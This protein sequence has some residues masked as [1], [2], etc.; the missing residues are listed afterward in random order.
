MLNIYIQSACK[1]HLLERERER[2][3]GSH[4]KLC[5]LK[6]YR[7]FY[8][9]SPSQESRICWIY[10]SCPFQGLAGFKDNVR[11]FFQT[12]LGKRPV[13]EPMFQ[14]KPKRCV[15]V[16]TPQFLSQMNAPESSLRGGAGPGVKT[17]HILCKFLAPRWR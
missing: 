7:I 2:S 13:E 1:N 12:D 9:P 11:I 3:G 8:W 6:W 14:M 4:K 5:F 16:I 17:Y 15:E 10:Q